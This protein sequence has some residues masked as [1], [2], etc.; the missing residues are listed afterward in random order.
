MEEFKEH[1]EKVSEMR[2]ELDPAVIRRVI[3]EV[4]DLRG[5]EKSREA[6]E[7]MNGQL[8]REEI[9]EA[10]KEMREAAPGVDGIKMCYLKEACE[11]MKDALIG[12]V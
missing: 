10:M 7:C 11:E 8:V 1:F 3:G 9:E 5:C 4:R 6:N 12:M 2:Y